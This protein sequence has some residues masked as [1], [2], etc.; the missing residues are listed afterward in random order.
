G[1]GRGPLRALQTVR[2][3]ASR[4]RSPDPTL[5]PARARLAGEG[6]ACTRGACAAGLARRA[7]EIAS[8]PRRHTRGGARRTHGVAVVPRRAFAPGRG[9]ESL[10]TAVSPTVAA[11]LALAPAGS[12]RSGRRQDGGARRRP[13]RSGPADRLLC[14]PFRPRL[15]RTLV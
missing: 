6:P 3:M 11:R 10:R 4:R 15:G 7:R 14:G 2:S 1:L 9:D 5:E 12:R 8:A 13:C